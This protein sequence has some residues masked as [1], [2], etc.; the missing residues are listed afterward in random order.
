MHRNS[1]AKCL[2][3]FQRTKV[4]HLSAEVQDSVQPEGSLHIWEYQGI[5]MCMSNC[6]G[7][8]KRHAN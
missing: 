8:C 3:I 6:L 1:C 7:T 2:H 5:A 4:Q